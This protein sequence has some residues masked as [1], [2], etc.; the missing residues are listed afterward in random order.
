MAPTL[1][2]MHVHLDFMRHPEAVAQEAERLGLGMFACTVT[3][4]G[5]QRVLP[6]LSDASNVRLGVGLHPWWVADGRCDAKDVEL[7]CALARDT[8]FVGEVGIDLSPRH[9]PEESRETQSLALERI[10]RA[11]SETSDPSCRKVISFHTVRSA[12]LA[13]DILERTGCLASCT[14]IFHWFSGTSDELHRALRG[15]CLVSVNEMMLRTRRGREYARQL[16]AERLLLETDLPPGED[17]DFSAQEIRAQLERTV[18]CIARIRDAS[19]QEIAHLTSENANR[20][21]G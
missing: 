5:F 11:C 18:E 9:A 1:W 8:R 2:D 21:L 12:G 15:G 6:A 7:I 16:P 10:A 17:V 14:C 19:L 4:E 20:I 13:L 3:P